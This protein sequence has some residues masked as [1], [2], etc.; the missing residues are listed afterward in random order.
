MP[1]LTVFAHNGPRS[2]C[3]ALPCH[4]ADGP[5]GAGLPSKF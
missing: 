1:E 5:R 3:G 4:F 2:F